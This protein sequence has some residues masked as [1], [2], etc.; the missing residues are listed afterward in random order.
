MTTTTPD[1]LA[2]A[3]DRAPAEPVRRLSMPRVTRSIARFTVL[4]AWRGHWLA[5]A[6]MMSAAIAGALLFA[7]E[8]ALTERQS[9]GI[10]MAAP[11]ARLVAVILLATFA[12]TALTRELGDR[13]IELVLAAPVPRLAWIVGKW[14]GLCCIGLGTAALAALPLLLQAPAGAVLLWAGSLWLELCLVAGLAL[15]LSISFSQL[16]AALLSLLAV[17]AMARLIGVVMLL[18]SRAPLEGM[19]VVGR[20]NDMLVGALA[21]GLPR[22][23]LF[24]RTDWLLAA[25]EGMAVSAIGAPVVQLAIYVGIVLTVGWLD[26]RSRRA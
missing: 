12:V 25:H 19:A 10:A 8:M 3:P 2:R 4:E 1:A 26:F 24:T 21:H 14:A 20:F 22:L 18:Q 13:S 16:P 15:L 17:Y 6:L 7:T 23:D 5:A 9:V 11:L